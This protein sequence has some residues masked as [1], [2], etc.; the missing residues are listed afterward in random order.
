MSET[1]IPSSARMHKKQHGVKFVNSR[2]GGPSEHK[3]TK[4]ASIKHE[5]PEYFKRQTDQK[6]AD[7]FGFQMKNK[8]C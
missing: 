6:K 7:Q 2:A 5:N 8:P 3:M 1:V 4:N